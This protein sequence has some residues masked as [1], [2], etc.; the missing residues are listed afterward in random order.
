MKHRG[1]G[2]PRTFDRSAALDRA[3]EIFWTRGY[4]T[5]SVADLCSALEI[6]PPS[7]YA[8][9][10]NKASLFMEAVQHY[11][12]VHWSRIWEE[13]RLAKDT[14]S[15]FESFFENSAAVLSSRNPPCGCLVMLASPD[16]KSESLDL[17]GAIK[18]L[19][20]QAYQMIFHR[21]NQGVEEGDLPGGADT[22]ALADVFL[23]LLYGMSIQARDG[24]SL[25]QLSEIGR[26]ALK[27]LPVNE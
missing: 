10:G 20:A 24:A 22:K 5:T 17:K 4:E 14:R 12:K 1:K 6:S 25:Q 23:T 2:R 13:L 15:A 7:L 9:F 16:D 19:R 8:A 21:L 26:T 27:L 11:E 3:L 18:A